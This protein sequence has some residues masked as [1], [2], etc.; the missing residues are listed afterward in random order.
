MEFYLDLKSK[1]GPHFLGTVSHSSGKFSRNLYLTGECKYRT[2][3]LLQE[4]KKQAFLIWLNSK[5]SKSLP[6][7]FTLYGPLL[8]VG[9]TSCR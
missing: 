5:L 9:S 8:H 3:Y 7:L 2:P 4:N 6:K 1:P